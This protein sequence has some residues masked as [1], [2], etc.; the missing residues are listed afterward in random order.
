M[1]H[2][3]HPNFNFCVQ[4]LWCL[5]NRIRGKKMSFLFV[6]HGTCGKRRKNKR[7][8]VKVIAE[9]QE[10]VIAEGNRL[11]SS[12]LAA[13]TAAI[14]SRFAEPGE[15]PLASRS[16]SS[17]EQSAAT[18]TGTEST[19]KRALETASVAHHSRRAKAPRKGFLLSF[20]FR[21]AQRDTPHQ[22]RRC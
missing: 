9:L 16:S 11:R 5:A 21:D 10:A 3:V 7:P 12:E 20:S 14:A 13:Q 19:A 22:R 15:Q 17:V 1:R 8:L 6:L 4:Q 18:T 2:R